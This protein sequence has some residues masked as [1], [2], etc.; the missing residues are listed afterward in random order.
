M[1]IAL[2][3][4]QDRPTDGVEDYCL[5]LAGALA[6]NGVDLELV[7]VPWIERGWFRALHQLRRDASLWK[8]RW[9][10][11]QYTALSWSRRGI[12]LG[13]LAILRSLKR[14][15]ARVAVVFHE[16][17]HQGGTRLIDRVRSEI[18]RWVI[19]RLYGAAEKAIFTIPLDTVSWLPSPDA[20]S[21][22]IP[23]GSNI[24]PCGERRAAV[25]TNSEGKSVV[26][27]GVTGAPAMAREVAEISAVL[28]RAR[29]ACGP[30]RL[31][32]VGRGS[33]ESAPLFQRHLEGSDVE[34]IARG[35]LPAAEVA[36]EFSRADVL[37]FMRGPVTL[38]RG[39]AIAGIACGLPVVGYQNSS[40]SF[41]IS[42]AGLQLAPCGDRDALAAALSRVLSDPG[43]RE[44]LRQKSRRAYS[45]YFSWDQIARKFLAAFPDE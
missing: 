31:V 21:T 45:E 13:A 7:R 30:L 38:T 35:I 27:F 5:F 44:C 41:P 8:D 24:P 10:L 9:I 37:L 43:L 2:L 15:G 40:T 4:R 20:K 26:V 6:S 12:P 22:F 1:M 23:I 32:L 3:G 33:A 17:T 11:V 42:E 36:S 16:T 25:E 28:R 18:Q 14:C 34:I 19:L 29:T 39:S